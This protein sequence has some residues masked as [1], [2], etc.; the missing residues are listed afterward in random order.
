MKVVQINAVY[1]TGSTG[2][3][4]E[5]LHRYLTRN[6]E[7]SY[8][9]WATACRGGDD[10]VFRI[11]NTFDHK[12]HSFFR[13]FDLGQGFHSKRATQA[14]CRRLDQ[15][16][17]DVVHLHNLH[18]NFIHLPTLLGY[19]A[20]RK[21]RVIITLHDHWFFTG[22]CT[23]CEKHGNCRRFE[24]GC[25][26]CPAFSSVA[27]QK[28]IET[29]CRKK[30]EG[31]GA[32]SDCIAVGVS[33]YITDLATPVLSACKVEVCRIYNW[34]NRNIFKPIAETD[35][36]RKKH[37]LEEGKAVIL[38]V[39]Q[40]WSERK[41]LNEMIRLAQEWGKTAEVVLIGKCDCH[42]SQPNLHAIGFTESREELAA[43]YS[44]A[45]VFVNP[46]RMETFGLVTA[47]ALSCGTPVALYNN[48]ALPELIDETCGVLAEDG[49]EDAMVRAV[50][51]ILQNGK[52]HYTPHCLARAEL[53]DQNRQPSMYR[54]LYQYGVCNDE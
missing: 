2:H 31:L 43:L 6:G 54:N 42:L 50:C 25:R 7:E 49:N 18:S 32:L 39:C 36:I 44:L 23:Y 41:G 27:L 17:P 15:L 1:G 12:L 8:V 46:S 34:V 3:I 30:Q 51:E 40:S 16:E 47:E 21:P 45:D 4:V 24:Q 9:F 33:Q 48:T 5:D 20:N 19:L 29:L 14:L 52:Q 11:G 22:Y 37:G 28:K 26:G 10:H 38:G 13:R 53:F 35:T